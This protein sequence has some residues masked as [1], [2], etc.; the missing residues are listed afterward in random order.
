L[1]VGWGGRRGGH[2]SG[3]G[4]GVAAGAAVR[5]GAGAGGAHPPLH[6]PPG[7]PRGPPARPYPPPLRRRGGSALAGG[8][9]TEFG[10]GGLLDDALDGW[11]GGGT[12][13]HQSSRGGVDARRRQWRSPPVKTNRAGTCFKVGDPPLPP[14]RGG[15]HRAKRVTAEGWGSLGAS[16]GGRGWVGGASG[17][18]QIAAGASREAYLSALSALRA[19]DGHGHDGAGGGEGHVLAA[20]F[21]RIHRLE[22]R[23]PPAPLRWGGG[24]PDVDPPFFHDPSHLR[25]QVSSHPF[26]IDT[27]GR[28]SGVS[29][30]LE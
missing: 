29:G 30:R 12:H 14:G 15:G 19:A 9:P 26:E 11:S 18:Q 28:G 27:R 22:A 10:F 24:R 17:Q 8:I 2:V 23:A 3:G 5:R 13:S 25:I 20:H 16:E 4:R 7:R 6:P 1:L 21:Q